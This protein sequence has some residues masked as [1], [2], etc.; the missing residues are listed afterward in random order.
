MEVDVG[1][2]FLPR[3]V[4]ADGGRLFGPGDV[5]YGDQLAPVVEIAPRRWADDVS[6]TRAYVRFLERAEHDERGAPYVLLDDETL[7]LP[8]EI[9]VLIEFQ[10]K[11]AAQLLLFRSHSYPSFTSA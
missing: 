11:D 2:G 9:I 4:P 5:A 8:E 7:E 6:E 10:M 3:L 1:P